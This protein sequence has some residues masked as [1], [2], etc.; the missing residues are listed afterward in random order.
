[1]ISAMP[2]DPGEERAEALLADR[3]QL[4]L[5]V[6]GMTCASCVRRVERALGRVPGVEDATVNLAAETALVL[7]DPEQVRVPDLEAAVVRAGYRVAEI[8]SAGTGAG[9]AGDAADEREERQQRELRSLRD[10]AL[11]SL[12]LGLLLML[13]MYLPL[14]LDQ[15]LLA[16]AL[17]VLATVV[18]FWAGGQ[19]YRGAWAAGRHGGA[20]M[21]TLIAVGTSAAYGYSAFVTLWP[22][23]AARWGIQPNLYFEA[24]SVIIALVLLGRW[25]E[26]RARSR[27]GQ[28]IERLMG[29]HAR[30]A[31]LVRGGRELDVPV[32]QVRVGDVIRVRPGEKVAVD[33]E[34]VEGRSAVDESMLTG[35]SLPVEKGPGDT[36]IGATLNATGTFLLRATRVGRDTTLAQIVRLVEE[37]QGSRAPMQRL[38]DTVSSYFVPAILG[39]AA[40]TFAG[41]LLLGPAHSA[42]DALQAAV[43]VLI[44]ACPCALGL[45]TPTAIMVGTGRAAELGIL[46]RGGEAL[47]QARRIDTVVLDKTGTLTEGRPRV[48]AILPVAGWAAEDVL[49]LAAGVEMTSEHPLAGAVLGRAEA[50][51]VDRPAATDF[52][53]EPGRGVSAVVEDRRVAIGSLAKAVELGLDLSEVAGEAERAA[54][55]GRTPLVVSVDGRVAGLLVMAD[56]LKPGAPRFVAELQAMGLEVWMLTG[57][58]Q[59]TAEAVAARAG[60]ER[61]VAGVLPQEKA[62]HVE[63]LQAEGRRVAMV[64][65]GINDA[66]ALARADLGIAIG[67]GADVAMAASDVTLVGGDLRGVVTAIALSRRTVRT[68][69]AG[70]FWAFAYNA[71]LVPVAMGVLHPLLGVMLSPVLAAAAMAMSSVS[72]VSN[73][74]RLRRFQAPTGPESILHPPLGERIGEYAYL[75]A[76]AV[77]ALAVA[78][79]R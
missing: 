31:R 15:A 1:M 11:V 53:Y 42:T 6:E 61:V 19:F 35:E 78:L 70:L 76:I 36:V 77:V 71:A 7:V 69:R 64:G 67:T 4:T 16:P 12:A 41:W 55:A 73:A 56:E 20:N 14:R 60:I 27:T 48:T 44:I 46:I 2:G 45:A 54:I 34:V 79:R 52:R 25:L 43:A 26:G 24:S 33:G 62:A 75:G 18:Q 68:I 66:P 72:V 5:A 10:R 59:R 40:L 74:L 50:D 57:D 63:R 9:L 23:L 37:A 13:A 8:P 32:E 22:Q 38:A 65:D 58:G 30:T 17:L 3:R 51:G 49:R 28:A 21:D 29:L 39:L 47:E